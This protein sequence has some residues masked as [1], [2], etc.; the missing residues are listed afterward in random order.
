LDLSKN[1]L[2]SEGLSVVSEALKSTS[3][4][5]LNIAENNLSIN[6]QRDKD[7]SGVIKFT[8]DMKDMGSLSKLTFC[9]ID[10]WGD[11]GDAVT[12]DTSMTEADF[13]GKKLGAAGAQ[14]LSA[15][16]S[17]EL[18]EAKGSL[19]RLDVSGNRLC[20]V[21][22][23]GGGRK[24]GTCDATGLIALAKSISNLKELNISGN[25]LKAE[26]AK[27]LVPA[28]EASG[29]LSSVNLLK[30]KIGDEQ[31]QSLIKIKKEKGM[32]SLCGLHQGQ[33]EADFSNQGLGAEDAKLIASDIQDMG[34]LSKLD[35]SGNNRTGSKSPNFIRPIAS[36]LKTN[37]SITELNISGNNL[38]AEATGIFSKDMKDMG[39]LSS[40]NLL[41]NSIG[42]E[43]AQALLKIKEAKPGLTTL[44][45][46]GG[47]ETE[48]D[49][50]GKGLGPGC[51]ILLAPEMEANG[52]LAS[53]D[54]SNNSI[55][56]QE[57]IK[58]ICTEKPIML[59]CENDE[60]E[61]ESESDSDS[62]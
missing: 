46:L 25:M 35:L 3:I 57:A 9:G 11:E 16:M 1:N 43:Q 27:V 17:T 39:S 31:M 48:L 53:L 7:M 49:L 54:I 45:G 47:D 61:S 37:T 33:T 13:S 41:G 44:C 59:T 28:I 23:D 29:S 12:I 26:G 30:N 62:D 22:I 19:S 60:S 51:A 2:R 34:S 38:D 20:G 24:Q 21:F 18:F 42:V 14:I 32:A 15:F 55:G 36:A 52:S 50:S 58:Q 10:R 4:K 5:Q 6:Q 8:E 56:A 40:A